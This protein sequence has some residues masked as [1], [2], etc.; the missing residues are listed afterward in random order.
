VATTING[1][2]T[3]FNSPFTFNSAGSA[4]TWTLQ[5]N[6]TLASLRATTLTAGT[7]SLGT[8]TLST[9]LFDS[10]NA[11]VRTIAF[12]TGKIVTTSAIT[13][14]VWT[15]ATITS[16]TITGT[17]LVECQGGGGAVTKTVTSGLITAA[18]NP[19]SLSLLD[20]G[21]TY[22]LT[23]TACNFRNL[24]FNGTQTV[25]NTAIT[26]FGNFTHLTTN[27]TTTFAAGAGTFTFSGTTGPINIT[28]VS[29]FTYDFPW[30]FNSAGTTFVLQN[31]FTVGSTRL[32]T[33]SNGILDVNNKTMSG[34]VSLTLTNTTSI[35]STG[36]TSAV[37]S[38]P[39]IQNSGTFTLGTN[40]TINNGLN[41]YTHN[42][43][44][45]NINSYVLSV[46]TFISN[47]S[48]T[49][50]I[51]FGTGKVV[52][53]YSSGTAA[54]VWNTSTLTGLTITG[55]PLVESQGGGGAVKTVTSGLI[56]AANNPISLSLLDTSATYT[57]TSAGC[58]FRNLVINGTQT[59]NSA[60]LSIFG[61]YT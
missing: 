1:G 5:N 33:F 47:N 13:S 28:P 50:T 43:G 42:A 8:Y 6:L 60:S 32:I 38:S 16:L 41:G 10:S 49:R 22:V 19:I 56:T 27:G 9:G 55:T 21:A 53:T 35:I 3:T 14:T 26:I 23:S 44:T 52:L 34:G 17:P 24:V 7:L 59:V 54:T 40:V 20:S 48:A 31:N 15:T 11:N 57:L 25:N 58:N 36:G 46:P 4:G 12:G 18:N 30:T 39:I 45:V 29:G 51:A 2:D 37:M 61:D